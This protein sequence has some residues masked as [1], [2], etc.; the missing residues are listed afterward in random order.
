MQMYDESGV[1]K[2]D[3]AIGLIS[4]WC[5]GCTVISFFLSDVI[6]DVTSNVMSDDMLV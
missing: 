4:K 1:F 6:S 3:L 2:F 5:I